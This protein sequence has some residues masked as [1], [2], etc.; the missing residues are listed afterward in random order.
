M[1]I[2]TTPIPAEQLAGDPVSEAD[3]RG[4][5]APL[6]TGM[7]PQAECCA[8]AEEETCCEPAAKPACCGTASAGGC[9]CR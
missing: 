5:S 2:A 7:T 8:P 1:S 3:G 6:F 9:G 4:G